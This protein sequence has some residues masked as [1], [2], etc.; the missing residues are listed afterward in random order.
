VTRRPAAPHH[1]GGVAELAATLTA[2]ERTSSDVPLHELLH[3]RAPHAVWRHTWRSTLRVLVLVCADVLTL[4]LLRIVL[5]AARDQAWFGPAL[6]SALA[7]TV[8]Q[9]AVPAV[10][11]QVAVLLGLTLCGGYVGGAR[12][13]HVRSVALG[14]ALGVLFVTWTALFG[15]LSA[16]RLLGVGVVTVG[17]AGTLV[18]VRLVLDIVVERVRPRAALALRA[19]LIAPTHEL[20]AG[21]ADPAFADP[22]EFRFV[23]QVDASSTDEDAGPLAATTAMMRLI[24]EKRADTV[25]LYGH[26]SAAA[27]ERLARVADA[28]GCNVV[29]LPR[30]LVLHDFEPQLVFHHGAPLVRLVRAGQRGRQLVV[31]RAMDIVISFILLVVLAP[32]FAAVAL[33]VRLTSRGPALFRQTRV[34]QG[35]RTFSMWK[36]RS[37][38]DG[39]EEQ[40]S[41]IAAGNVYGDDPLFKVAHDPRITACGRFLRRT[42]LDELPQ[43]WN[44]LRGEM[45]LVGPRPP[46]PGEVAR[47]QDAHLMRLDV[48]PGL[49]GPWQVSGRNRVVRFEDVLRLERSYIEHWSF[50]QDVM[51]LLRTLP[52]VIRMDGAQ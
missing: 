39:A 34:G 8:P 11:L 24:D 9:G 20:G 36:F 51:I 25:V 16:S 30:T 37:M 44:V 28:A 5:V 49:T 48:R 52:A 2:G 27:A 6:A 46:L 45:S 17:V 41:E 47:Y 22:T 31:K 13:R 33:A 12:R 23:G 18:V 7:A 1:R 26:L 40:Q 19:I 21:R 15:P 14:A 4:E 38:V 32:L 10:P 29:C 35:G 42:S 3:A 50:A 43:F